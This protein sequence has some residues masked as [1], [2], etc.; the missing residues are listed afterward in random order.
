MRPE[1]AGELRNSLK[2]L[3]S[4]QGHKA[5]PIL[6]TRAPVGALG[7]LALRGLLVIMLFAIA[8]LA[9]WL[10][11]AGLKDAAD[12]A[13]S[14][15]DV[16]YFT[17]VTVSTV[18]YGDIVPVSDSARLLDAFLVTPIRILVWFVFIGTA[19]QLVIQRVIED[20][21]MQRLQRRLS[22]HV[23]V[24]GFSNSGRS[25]VDE[26][27][28]DGTAPGQVVVIE[29]DPAVVQAAI[30]RGVVV[31]QGDAT[32]EEMLR[33]A[34]VEHARGLIVAVGRDDAALMI[35]V[36]ARAVGANARIVA[37]VH[38]RE[39]IRLLRNGGANVVVTPWTY[40][41]YLLADGITQEHTVDLIQDALS[42]DGPLR[43]HERPP[44]PD[45]I[46]C[47]ARTLPRALIYGVVRDGRRVMFWE[48]PELRVEAGDVL[49]VMDAAG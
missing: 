7:V 16:I 31:L 14:L 19:Y 26:L 36:T 2:R 44:R 3:R 5:A 42:H 33:I 49:I 46:G 29:Q 39:N 38:E 13:V 4:L 17:I 21:R 12:G 8:L 27:L 34:G 32:R 47:I 48:Q 45:E 23:I 41:G 1:P 25:A 24:C 28:A 15:I 40:S 22:D 30:D 9:F 11:R 10:D 43:L 37:S 18:G 20:W 35:V 6:F